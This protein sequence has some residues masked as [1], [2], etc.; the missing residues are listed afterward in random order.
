VVSDREWADGDITAH[1]AFQ[2][3]FFD[4]VVVTDHD[5]GATGPGPRS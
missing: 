1:V 2:E 3:Q 4:S 5:G